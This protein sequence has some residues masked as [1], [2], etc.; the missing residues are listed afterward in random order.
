MNS[1]RHSFLIVILMAAAAFLGSC[2]HIATKSLPDFEHPF[3]SLTVT[4]FCAACLSLVT[5]LVIANS[6]KICEAYRALDIK[7]LLIGLMLVGVDGSVFYLY[8]KCASGLAETPLIIS[9]AQTLVTVLA[10]VL[11]FSERPRLSN[12]VG[13]LLC[14]AG[15]FL[16]AL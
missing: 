6:P 1:K 3:A 14:L 13:M 12:Y 2:Y 4:Y 10:G 15:A 8:S 7:S 9:S 5:L 16:A 11:L